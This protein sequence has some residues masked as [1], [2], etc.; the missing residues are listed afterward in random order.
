M[1]RAL[2]DLAARRAVDHGAWEATIEAVPDLPIQFEIKNLPAGVRQVTIG[3]AV[4]AHGYQIGTGQ[5][6]G[7]NR[8]M[9][10]VSLRPQNP[11]ASNLRAEI[12]A[13]VQQD[14]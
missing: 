14:P 13:R 7:G 8:R 5:H 9:A 3:D 4:V 12:G 10:P 1:R 2:A 6:G 11:C